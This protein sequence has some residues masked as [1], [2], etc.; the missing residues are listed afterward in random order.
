MGEGTRGLGTCHVPPLQRENA[1][2]PA[3]TY[4]NQEHSYGASKEQTK[5]QVQLPSDKLWMADPCDGLH[6]TELG[7]VGA[8]EPARETANA[9]DVEAT[10][11]HI[12]VM[13]G[14]LIGARDT[15]GE[16]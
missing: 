14:G 16:S 7:D 1:H 15:T 3:G 6:S 9:K 12:T 11:V 8:L 2:V 10:R 4:A 5:Q 13:R